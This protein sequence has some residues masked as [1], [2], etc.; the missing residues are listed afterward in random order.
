[1]FQHFWSFFSNFR[2]PDYN[3]LMMILERIGRGVMP[4]NIEWEAIIHAEDS[5]VNYAPSADALMSLGSIGRYLGSMEMWI[6]VAIGM[7]LL[8]GS[9]WFRRRATDN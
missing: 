9:V 7:L 3:L 8:A 2:L 5:S 4:S 6:G 1:M